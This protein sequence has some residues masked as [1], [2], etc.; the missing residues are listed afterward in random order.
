QRIAVL[1]QTIEP[2][3]AEKLAGI[4]M[5][6]H[7]TVLVISKLRSAWD[8]EKLLDLKRALEKFLSP[9]HPFLTKRFEIRI[10]AKELGKHEKN[11]AYVNRV[12]GVVQNQIF[13]KLRFNS[14]FIRARISRDGKTVDT[15][16]SHDGQ[17]VL[18]LKEK[19][20]LG[21]KNIETFIYYLNPYKKAY[22][23]RQTGMRSIDFGSVFLFLNGFR[24][25]PYGDRGD[26]WLGLD[27]RK[28]QGT[29]RYLSSRDLVGRV[30]V[31]DDEELFKPISSREGL[32]KTKEFVQLKEEFI[33][34]AIRRLEAFVV[35]CLNWDSIPAH[36]R[37][38]L[39]ADTG[40]D[41]R[42]T[43]EEYS[44]SWEKKKQR[45][46]LAMMTLI[47][48]SR[49]RIIRLWFNP[50]LLEGVHEQRGEEVRSLLEQIGGFGPSQVEPGLKRTLARLRSIVEKKEQEARVARNEAASLRVAVARKDES[51]SKLAKETET[52][53][54]QSLFLQS[55]GSR[56]ADSLMEFHHE[57]IQNSNIIDNYVGRATR[58]L[59][60]NEGTADALQAIEKISFAN[61]RIL[62]IAQFATKANFR[63]AASKEPTDIPAFFE[64]YM[65]NV[66]KDFVATGLSLDVTNSVKEPFE[67]PARRIELSIVIDNII[68]NA[69]K[70]QARTV[71]V[72][73]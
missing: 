18:T 57:I 46:A 8:R 27:L 55:I 34:G 59:R 21:I 28:T 19:N 73:I 68:G 20:A 10:E 24:I 51:I 7:G 39:R 2:A 50:A 64:Q 36:L 70:A 4:E 43:D 42:N 12:N 25:A 17:V 32:K 23:K 1:L 65:L 3:E 30:E 53:R 11:E 69:R 14:T 37:S 38:S 29:T 40:L 63:S 71:R 48:S 6:Q 9:H 56:D 5:P 35:D 22:F 49:E 15:T 72:R 26:D 60:G 52:F 66:A 61:K 58:A 45:I 13:S 16:L 31:F 47:G 62:A 33:L 44:E 41:W 54:A 67:I